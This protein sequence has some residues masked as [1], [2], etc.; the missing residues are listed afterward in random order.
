[1][2][3]KTVTEVTLR[4][5]GKK[6]TIKMKLTDMTPAEAFAA[7]AEQLGVVFDPDKHVAVADG[8]TIAMDGA[9]PANVTALTATTKAALG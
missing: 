8:D 5:P 7:A 9:L 2:S 1:M 6:N 4:L 3:D